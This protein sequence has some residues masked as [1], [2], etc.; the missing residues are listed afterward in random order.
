MNEPKHLSQRHCL[1]M[2]AR[3]SEYVDHETASDVERRIDSHLAHCPAC[4]VC[5]AT[6]QRT[7][8][9]CKGTDVARLPDDVAQRLKQMAQKLQNQAGAI[10]RGG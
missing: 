2:F 4:R 5:L 9:L 8:A 3:L 1:E 10:H 7:I 6:L